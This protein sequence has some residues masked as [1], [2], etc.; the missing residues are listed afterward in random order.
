MDRGIPLHLQGRGG[1]GRG[2]GKGGGSAAG[3][4]LH[5]QGRGGK[6]RGKGKG[7]ESAAGIPLHLQ[8]R[9]GKGRGKGKGG[10]FGGS[11]AWH[12]ER[13]GSSTT[14]TNCVGG[15]TIP[16]TTGVQDQANTPP[17]RPKGY[18]PEGWRTDPVLDALHLGAGCTSVFENSGEMRLLV[19]SATRLC[20]NGKSTGS[21][22][23]LTYLF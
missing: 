9:G 18:V 22:R 21:R 17:A 3:T 15:G 1:K 12:F 20:S 23:G 6:G 2:N 14:G 19:D 16:P 8:G 10:D 13:G 7:G 4:P 5:L 11:A